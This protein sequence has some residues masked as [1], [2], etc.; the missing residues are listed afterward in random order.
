MRPG[1]PLSAIAGALSYGVRIDIV[2]G[3]RVIAADVPVSGALLEHASSRTVR[4]RLTYEAPASWAPRYPSDPLAAYGQRS[5][6]TII[7]RDAYGHTWESPLGMFLHQPSEAEATKTPVE[8]LDLMQMLE[9]DPMAWPSSPPAGARLS[10]ELQRLAGGL[11]TALNAGVPD[12]HVPITTQWGHSRSEAVWKLA[13]SKGV[14]LRMEADGVLH[15]YPL[16][17]AK[18]VDAI[19]ETVDL[20][21]AAG[22]GLLLEEPVVHVSDKR[23]PNRWVVTGTSSQGGVDTKW[24]ATR[25]NNLPPFDPAV[26]GRV[27]AHR[28]F[29]AADSQEAVERAADTYMAQDLEA[30][31]TATLSIVPDP[32]LE[33]GDVIGVKTPSQS[34]AGRVV[35]YSLPL[36]DVSASMRVDIEVLAR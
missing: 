29:S 8:A 18:S 10:S 32:R 4:G 9:E 17:D 2:H 12:S 5:R 31:Q 21:A 20:G 28:E 34:L 15:A 11:P 33:V 1:P 35:A 36:S 30:L 7:C 6:A 23:T 25:E 24:T 22:N 19:Y 14:G 26:Y 27:T 16:R 3:G 13:E